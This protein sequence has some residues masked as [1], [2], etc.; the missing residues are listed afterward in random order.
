MSGNHISNI[1]HRVD[2]NR[3]LRL[4]PDPPG[5]NPWG[6]KL[7]IR[8]CTD[9]QG[10]YCDI[11]CN[12]CV[13]RYQCETTLTNGRRVGKKYISAIWSWCEST[14]VQLYSCTVTEIS[15]N[16]AGASCSKDRQCCAAVKT[17]LISDFEIKEQTQLCLSYYLS[18]TFFWYDSISYMLSI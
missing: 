14:V 4:I 8:I 10:R 6:Y 18:L 5:S 12:S 1:F 11:Q 9:P 15:I 2:L 16:P 7:I 17:I 13:A 3:K